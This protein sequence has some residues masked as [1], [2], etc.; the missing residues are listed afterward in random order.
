MRG[1]LIRGVNLAV[2]WGIVQTLYAKLA[3]GGSVPAALTVAG[4]CLLG[5]VAMAWAA[6]DH[7]LGNTGDNY[8]WLKAA[9]LAGILGSLLGVVGQAAF[10]DNTG[11]WAIGP[12]LIGPA[13]FIG[14][15]VLVPSW[16]GML[17]GRLVGGREGL[18]RRQPR[19]RERSLPEG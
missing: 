7:L 11:A 6:I 8:L 19:K 15:L 1:W 3:V 14:L 5:A 13:P 17:I 16:L 2:L 12:A 10:V 18:R 9:L 4:L